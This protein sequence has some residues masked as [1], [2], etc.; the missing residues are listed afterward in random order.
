[1]KENIIQQ[2][3]F[4]FAV[5]IIELYK[6]LVEVKKEYILSKQLLRSG[7]SIGANIEE[8]LGG[9]SKKDFISKLSIAYKE[10][11][12]TKYWLSLLKETKYYDV[13]SCDTPLDY[14]FAKTL[15]KMGKTVKVGSK[16]KI[17]LD[18]ICKGDHLF[19]V[20]FTKE[21]E[22]TLERI[23]NTHK[24]IDENTMDDIQKNVI[25][26]KTAIRIIH[27]NSKEQAEIFRKKVLAEFNTAVMKKC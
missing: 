16:L 23:F 7:T 3:S 8:A 13:S 6:Y 24:I 9:Q 2:K 14:A 12:E 10:T 17:T 15:E 25:V 1:M 26:K 19:E 18:A 4:T 11:R 21:L 27:T 5:K 22:D 20:S